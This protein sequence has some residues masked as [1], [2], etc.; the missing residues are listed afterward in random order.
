M[1]KFDSTEDHVNYDE[2]QVKLGKVFHPSDYNNIFV[3]EDLL[4]KPLYK[5]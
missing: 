4:L 2:L 5:K 1:M 3:T